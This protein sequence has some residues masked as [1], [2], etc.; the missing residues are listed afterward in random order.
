[1]EF[2]EMKQIWDTQNDRPV[3]VIDEKAMQRYIQARKDRVLDI[4]NSSELSLIAI[5]LVAGA[6]LL[7]I[8]LRQSGANLFM[9][10][11]SAWMFMTVG[12]VVVSR[13]RRVRAER[14]FDRSVH[15]DLD[16]AISLASYQ[17]R[18][19]RM[20][21]WN[22]LPMGAIMI[23]SGWEAGKFLK[24]TAVILVSY[25]FA[26]YV[27]RKGL[28]ASKGRRRELDALKSDLLAGG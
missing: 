6:I 21:R 23:G 19:S 5:N 22:L 7:V 20:I 16:H 15:G 11:E 24:V 12:Y 10:L 14:Q 26:F 2:D 18:L 3:Y 17:V 27:G 4:A 28:R 13:I 8:N 9:Y 25:V 1:M